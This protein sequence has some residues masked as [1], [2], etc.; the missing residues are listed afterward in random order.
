MT[1][2]GRDGEKEGHYS[3]PESGHL[4]PYACM[5]SGDWEGCLPRAPG[6]EGWLQHIYHAGR[7]GAR[8]KLMSHSWLLLRE[9]CSVAGSEGE[10]ASKSLKPTHLEW[11][12]LETSNGVMKATPCR[13]LFMLGMSLILHHLQQKIQGHLQAEPHSTGSCGQLSF[14]L[15]FGVGP[16]LQKKGGHRYTK[17]T[18]TEAQSWPPV[19]WLEEAARNNKLTPCGQ[20]QS[21][22]I[23]TPPPGS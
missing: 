17:T 7:A 16:M 8:R 5:I 21:W 4:E 2:E 13:T 11:K 20:P 10:H 23:L 19:Q 22:S 9:L 12:V 14:S 18:G 6:L 3:V 1:T 15:I